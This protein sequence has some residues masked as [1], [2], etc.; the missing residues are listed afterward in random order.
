MTRG[1]RAASS[2]LST[3]STAA[4]WQIIGRI[5]AVE[6]LRDP[7]VPIFPGPRR[8]QP[9]AGTI[10]DAR[11][12]LFQRRFGVE[13]MTIQSLA[14]PENHRENMQRLVYNRHCV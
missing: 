2:P 10:Y 3:D 5:V 7:P 8:P 9:E 12:L 13:P 14:R 11:E 4:A 1:S 6:T